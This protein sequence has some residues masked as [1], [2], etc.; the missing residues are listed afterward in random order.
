MTR[1]AFVSMMTC[2]TL[3]WSEDG[4]SGTATCPAIHV[5]QTPITWLMEPG[6]K[7][8]T[9]AEV[10]SWPRRSLIPWASSQLLRYRSSYK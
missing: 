8:Q 10:T 5:A 2:S 4:Q 6:Q 7:R 9:R 3:A 1:S